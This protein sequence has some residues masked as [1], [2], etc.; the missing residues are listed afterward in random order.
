MVALKSR[1]TVVRAEATS[2]RLRAR[3]R[4]CRWRAPASTSS[5]TRPSASRRAARCS[6]S[7]FRR[8]MRATLRVR[9]ASTPLRTH[10]SS[11]ASSLSARAKAS[12]SASSSRSFADF[13][14][15]EVAGVAAQPAAVELDDARATASRNARSCVTRTRLPAKPAWHRRA[16][17]RSHA[18]ASRSRWFVGSSSSST[19]GARDQRLRQRDALLQCRPTA[20]RRARRR[21]SARRCSVVSTRCSQVQPPSASMRVCS[22]SRSSPSACA[23]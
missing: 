8:A 10:A 17:P 12:A 18:I 4:S 19:S 7:A 23:S 1:T 2:R 6:R 20:C 13:E 5:R 15:G 22:A 11:C 9:R 21:R 14:G 16:A 3:R